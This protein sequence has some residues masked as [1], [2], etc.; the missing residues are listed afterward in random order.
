MM[1]I[2]DEDLLDAVDAFGDVHVP[3]SSLLA[4]LCE[5]GFAV[6]ASVGTLYN[7]VDQGILFVN[8]TG[9]IQRARLDI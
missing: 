7:L 3:S 2:T 5:K 4:M 8:V 6:S 1:A 9:G